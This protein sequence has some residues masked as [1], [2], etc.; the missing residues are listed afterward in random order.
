MLQNSL[1][2]IIHVSTFFT[3]HDLDHW[4]GTI[5]LWYSVSISLFC[6][7]P[8]QDVGGRVQTETPVVHGDRTASLASAAIT[9]LTLQLGWWLGACGAVA[10]LADR[11][12]T[13][14]DLPIPLSGCPQRRWRYYSYLV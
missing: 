7:A 1:E 10:A 11:A 12:A 8:A 14:C 6:S 5:I 2:V 3:M 9:A 4:I 13:L